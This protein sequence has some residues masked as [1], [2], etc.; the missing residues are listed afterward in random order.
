MP[1]IISSLQGINSAVL[2][3]NRVHVPREINNSRCFLHFIW[4]CNLKVEL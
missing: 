4:D 2:Q 3:D 1:K